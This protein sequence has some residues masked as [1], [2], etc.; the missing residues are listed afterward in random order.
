MQYIWGEVRIFSV[1]LKAFQFPCNIYSDIKQSS[2]QVSGLNRA[3]T[4]FSNCFL[5]GCNFCSRSDYSSTENNSLL[6]LFHFSL[7]PCCLYSFFHIVSPMILINHWNKASSIFELHITLKQFK[8]LS[9]NSSF[10]WKSACLVYFFSP[11]MKIHLLSM[12]Y[13]N[14]FWSSNRNK[15]YWFYNKLIDC[16]CV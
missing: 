16:V 13:Y 10:Y 5:S 12:I 2:I 11:S 6:V 4:R 9:V 8:S 14:Y 3:R 15:A 1:F 7:I